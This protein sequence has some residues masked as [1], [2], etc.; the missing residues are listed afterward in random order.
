MSIAGITSINDPN[1]QAEQGTSWELGSAWQVSD[2]L[3][4]GATYY[5]T[6]IQNLITNKR[7]APPPNIVSQRIN[8]GRAKIS[9]VELSAAS[10]LASWLDM[11]ASLAFIE[12]EMLE[13]E[14]DPLSVGKRLI[15]SP[16]NIFSILFTA[17]R[18][19]WSGTLSANYYSKIYSTAQN[20]DTAEGVPGAYDPRTLVNGKLMYD[21]S[22]DIK[23]NLSVNNLLDEKSYSYFLNPG[24]SLVAGLDFAL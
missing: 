2:N 10:V 15:D 11:S 4:T 9:G 20:T 13:N 3:K 16:R 8:A 14:A 6:L 18:G 24:R 19:L 21:F 1:L 22:R 23:G 7:L 5:Q 17:H 12:S